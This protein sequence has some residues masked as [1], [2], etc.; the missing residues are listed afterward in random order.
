MAKKLA[1]KAVDWGKD[2]RN[3]RYRS[4]YVEKADYCFEKTY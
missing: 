4:T 1:E 3:I 2:R